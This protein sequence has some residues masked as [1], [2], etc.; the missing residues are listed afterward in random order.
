MALTPLP[1]MTARALPLWM[2]GGAEEGD[3]VK[4]AECNKRH[5]RYGNAPR[6]HS[7]LVKRYGGRQAGG[8]RPLGS[9]HYVAGQNHD[10]DG[11]SGVAKRGGGQPAALHRRRQWRNCQGKEDQQR[12]TRFGGCCAVNQCRKW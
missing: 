5:R 4:N 2:A 9:G 11:Q 10:A 1:A 6:S 12:Q 8:L 7:E 3:V